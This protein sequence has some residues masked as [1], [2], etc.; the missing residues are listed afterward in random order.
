MTFVLS[1]PQRGMLSDVYNCFA[2]LSQAAKRANYTGHTNEFN[3]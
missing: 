2:V 3:R 1:V